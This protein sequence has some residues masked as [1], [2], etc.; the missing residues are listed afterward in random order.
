MQI[1]HAYTECK[2][3]ATYYCFVALDTAK[4]THH[5]RCIALL[6]AALVKCTWYAS[7]LHH[8]VVFSDNSSR[9]AWYHGKVSVEG[10]SSRWRWWMKRQS[11]HCDFEQTFCIVVNANRIAVSLNAAKV[12]LWWSGCVFSS[13]STIYTFL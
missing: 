10:I 5:K 8:A 9:A 4:Y 2:T 1:L 11:R 3:I 12:Q 7:M 6:E 13:L